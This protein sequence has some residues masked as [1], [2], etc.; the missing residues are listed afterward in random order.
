MADVTVV[1]N[2]L[3]QG[4]KVKNVVVFSNFSDPE[5]ELQ[6]FADA[7]RAAYVATII[8]LLANEWSLRDLTFIF[9]QS[10]PV[11]SIVVPFTAG[12]VPGGHGAPA[13]ATQTALLGSTQYQ[14]PPPNR[15][16]FYQAGVNQDSLAQDGSWSQP[17]RDGLTALLTTFV[18]GIVTP[19]SQMYMRIARRTPAGLIEISSPVDTVIARA[20]PATQRSRR[21][22]TGE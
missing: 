7:V 19:T 10:L 15:G 6:Q 21:V 20:Y 22:G 18:N 12:P 5:P 13:V 2:Q 4:Q 16:R 8:P 9:N 17:A 14:G 11:Y 1:F 3:F